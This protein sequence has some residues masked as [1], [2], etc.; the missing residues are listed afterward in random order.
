MG[1]SQSC[2]ATLMAKSFVDWW[3]DAGLQYLVESEPADWLAAESMSPAIVQDARIITT[4]E[5]ALNQPVVTPASKRTAEWPAN[6]KALFEA[7]QS[8]RSLPGN[9]YGP[10][11]AAPIGLAEAKYMVISDFPEESEL[12]AGTM[13]QLPLLQNMLRA[14]QIPFSSCFF[15]SLSYTRPTSGALRDGDKA[16]LKDFIRHQ[17]ALV[18]PQSL[19]LLGTNTAELLLERDLMQ[20]RGRLH[21]INHNIGKMAALATFHPRTLARQPALKAKSWQDLQIFIREDRT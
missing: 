11:I 14:A 20:A 1:E 17:I 15:A 18:A 8:D 2:T 7:V 16:G 5:Q 21:T 9:S 13:G 19:L 10:A 12:A 4:N 3:K 6:L